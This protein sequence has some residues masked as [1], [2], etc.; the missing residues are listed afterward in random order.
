MRHVL[1]L[2]AATL[3]LALPL[4]GQGTIPGFTYSYGITGASSAAVDQSLHC[5]TNNCLTS[6]AQFPEHGI[7]EIAASNSMDGTVY[8]L[9]FYGVLYGYTANGWVE[10]ASAL[11]NPGG[12]Q[13][14]HI[15][16][17]AASQVIA[18]TN[19]PYKSD[20]TNMYVM[21]STGTGWD[22][23]NEI[24]STN[25]EIAY[26]GTIAGNGGDGGTY[27][28][29][30]GAWTKLSAAADSPCNIAVGDS[31]HIWG[32]TCAGVL[33]S[34]NGS[35]FVAQSPAPRSLRRAR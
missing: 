24:W 3:L 21:N 35:A 28:R 12:N 6:L 33:E 14:T 29:L 25:S 31:T 18:M 13:I 2:F 27:A 5:A 30:N 19:V 7:V 23:L 32:V 10:S 17:G 34:W 1:C 15:S 20:A 16:V 9:D 22:A 26:D 8:G 4:L 11:Q